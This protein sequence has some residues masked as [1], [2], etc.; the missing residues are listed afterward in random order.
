MHKERLC[1]GHRGNLKRERN[2]SRWLIALCSVVFAVFAAVAAPVQITEKTNP[3]IVELYQKL[4]D[5][6]A[7]V[8]GIE[9]KRVDALNENLNAMRENEQR[10]ENRILGATTTLATGMGAMQAATGLAE[11]AADE[12]ALADM[13]AYLSTFVCEFGNGQNVEYGPGDV[14]LPGGNEL[15]EYY[16]EYKTLA[17]DLR[18]TKVALGLAP[19]IESEEILERADTGL[20]DNV[21]IGK[22]SGMY[23]SL[24]RG[25]LNPDGDDAA[26]IAADTQKSAEKLK[27]GA[28]AAGAGVV[29]GIIGNY[30][31]NKDAPKESSKQINQ[32]YD[33]QV[34]KI[35]QEAA[36]IET[37]LDAAIA[38]NAAAVREYNAA[39]ESAR[40]NV[41][42]IQRAPTDC[43]ELFGQYITDVSKLELVENETD[44]VPDITLPEMDSDLL[45]K[46]VQCKN[47]D[48]MFNAE[49]KTC[50]CP[51]ERPL[52]QDG[53]CIAKPAEHEPVVAVPGAGDGEGD[54]VPEEKSQEEESKPD[55]NDPSICA[56]GL[57]H[58][59]GFG[60]VAGE[61]RVGDRCTSA[62]VLDGKVFKRQKDGTCGC[63]AIVCETRAGRAAMAVGGR[64]VCDADRGYKEEKGKCVC[65]TD[66]GYKLVNGQCVNQNAADATGKGAK[67]PAA[68]A[69]QKEYKYY[70]CGNANKGTGNWDAQT[71]A[72]N[73]N[74]TCE[75]VGGAFN[76][77]NVTP[78][79][80][81]GL[82]KEW[83]LEKYND[84][85]VC[86]DK[87]HRTSA[88][89][90]SYGDKWRNCVSTGP[91]EKYYEF[92]FNSLSNGNGGFYDALCSIWGLKS[93]KQS[94]KKATKETCDKISVAVARTFYPPDGKATL[95]G[96]ECRINEHPSATS[97]SVAF[98]NNTITQEDLRSVGNMKPLYFYDKS[99]QVSAN[100]DLYK[101]ITSY[102]F[103]DLRLPVKEFSCGAGFVDNTNYFDGSRQQFNELN[104]KQRKCIQDAQ[105][106][107]GG[108]EHAA[109]AMGGAVSACRR[110]YPVNTIPGDLLT[111]AY[112]NKPIDFLF[113]K[114]DVRWNQKST[115]GYQ[116]MRCLSEGGSFTGRSCTLATEK[117]CNDFNARFKKD[118]PNAKG[119]KW[120]S[121]LQTC[122]LLDAKEV[123]NIQKVAEVTGMVAVTLV[124]AVAGG[125]IVWGLSAVEA[126]AL[127]FE[128]ATADKLS[129]W[130]EGFIVDA[131]RC[132]DSNC[133]DR[134][135]KNH[136]ARVIYGSRQFNDSQN[137]AIAT[138]MQRL[139]ELLDEDILDK[140]VDAG[141]SGGYIGETR[142]PDLEK[143]LRK[144]YNTKL[145]NGE[146]ALLGANY[147]STVLTFA[148]VIGAGVTA[149][150][151]QAFKRNWIHISEA[152]QAKWLKYKILKPD[153]VAG[154]APKATDTGTGAARAMTR[155]EGKR[156]QEIDARIAELE[157][158]TNRTADEAAELTKLR[159]ERNT[160]LNKVGTKDADEVAK[161]SAAAYNPEIE[162]AQREYQKLLKERE[163]LAKR[164]GTDKAPGKVEV[165]TM[166]KQIAA[167]EKKLKDLGADVEPV[168]P[169]WGNKNPTGTKPK[170]DAPEPKAEP[171]TAPKAEP[172]TPT[173]APVTP[174]SRVYE[175][176][177]DK[178]KADIADIKSGKAKE[179]HI[180]R[181]QLTDDEWKI[182]KDDLAKDGLEITNGNTYNIVKKSGKADEVAQA[183]SKADDA[184][185]ST[186][187]ASNADD[188]A[189]GAMNAS[190]AA[191]QSLL[192]QGF[193]EYKDGVYLRSYDIGEHIGQIPTG[194]REIRVNIEGTTNG[195]EMLAA[196]T[197]ADAA[198][199][200]L[201]WNANVGIN[202]DFVRTFNT[203]SKY[204]ISKLNGFIS[205]R[206]TLT[207][208]NGVPVY[209]SDFGMR[210]GRPIVMIEIKGRKLP[211]YISTGTAGKMQVPTGKWEF[212]GGLSKNSWFAKGTTKDILNHY[213]S[214]E[215]KQIADALDSSIG[216]VRNVECFLHNSV[217]E[218]QN[219]QGAVAIIDGVPNITDD[220]INSGLKHVNNN[221]Y[222]QEW[223][224][225]E[226]I[227]EV[228]DWLSNQR[229][230]PPAAPASSATSAS[231]G[232]ASGASNAGARAAGSTTNI[233][234]LRNRASSSF[235]KYLSQ[236]K[237]NKTG[238]GAKLPK[239]RLTDAEW[240][241]VNK[242]L[243]RENVQLVEVVQ[244]GEHY[245]QFRRADA[246][247]DAASA[248][249]GAGNAARN[250]IPSDF[251]PAAKNFI[252][253]INEVGST[254][255]Y[256]VSRGVGAH[257][258]QS[259]LSRQET[260]YIR[261]LLND[262]DDL[263]ARNVS[264]PDGSGGNL[265]ANW[266]VTKKTNDMFV[267][268]T[269]TV[270][271]R[272]NTRPINNLRGKSITTINGKSVFLEPLDNG[273]LIGNVSGRPVVVVN[274]NG[275]RIPFYASSG[276]AG[277]LDVP[278]GKWEVFFGFGKGT[279]NPGWFNK[280]GIDQIVGHYG[281]PELKKIAEALDNVI[282]D[283]RNI[284]D[285]FATISRKMYN[286]K[287]I[288][289]SYDGPV[290]SKDF[291]NSLLDFIPADYGAGNDQLLRNI[292][293]V[294]SYFK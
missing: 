180:P 193:H 244:D 189:R 16:N 142:N 116:G 221:A 155:A 128:A 103:N 52:E 218:A 22:T 121:D 190:D 77:R 280:G 43:Q 61:T 10:I 56:V 134:V 34:S 158:K 98:L 110:Q 227:L 4:Q 104:E 47:K 127:V 73:P 196:I 157:K 271:R 146:R 161:L 290:A 230:V 8:S 287:G 79:E 199:M 264:Q 105:A 208:I 62:Q 216:D 166:D 141:I 45:A 153:D 72:A 222:G 272:I 214:P 139:L 147:A 82:M 263:I 258:N 177:G 133:A 75:W 84:T 113:K 125:P 26:Q 19:G 150:L 148:T 229:A 285:V 210:S 136:I 90:Q 32:E 201:K 92:A 111:C 44:S 88:E 191:K 233:N 253:D 182:L 60:I 187:K 252:N 260:D 21:A 160:I 270:L 59:A 257:A 168:E 57:K 279:R 64:C 205:S 81:D 293:Y 232:A 91:K 30:K 33:A 42:E 262:R 162:N 192:Q 185:K 169:L 226:D 151:R 9:S 212:F 94:C 65:D 114:L 242:S 268:E 277:K 276:S 46:C 38:E 55:P 109:A 256:A 96:S 289:A 219:A 163:A 143:S 122:V 15:M 49:T 140:M 159:Q 265:G 68:S 234:T 51:A 13:R 220:V 12:R 249:R 3:K 149:G 225:T 152:R 223:N 40:K 39:V 138:Q 194:V 243:A 240:E 118:Y 247:D 117:Q 291:I 24:A 95:N 144:Y 202:G 198:K 259:Q 2:K 97:G 66:R 261:Q 112:D 165:Q 278:T 188:A 266:F 137:K 69:P 145:T 197:D 17:E 54:K 288:V 203:Q 85:I 195:R 154:L 237:T 283:Q 245:M 211:F 14:T 87:S 186:N 50:A 228:K 102:L 99:F 63:T 184:A 215:L 250:A 41:D 179:L 18:K 80:A 181:G 273:G 74:A 294:K 281:S 100:S 53:K 1:F 170:T 175:K 31:I 119:M 35:N 106:Y 246:V 86:D 89:I 164:M 248:A 292:E 236:V 176:L 11:T 255:E 25:I 37:E 209:I 167:A 78:M 156:I 20:Y 23:A 27:A 48:A 108:G 174:Q 171:T 274:Y 6:R 238:L 131:A 7:E 83:A 204:R 126:T 213:K 267:D 275:H 93:G 206:T 107:S 29:G 241:A 71:K 284:E 135:L 183:T 231:R 58:T 239:A 235:D 28:I 251:S 70:N 101:I 282:G 173:G 5:K 76:R 124:S 115:A 130:A 269:N 254:K 224:F 132:N 172:V 129:D 120:N 67:Q 36:Q 200:G 286:G 217:R 207:N 178:V 123:R